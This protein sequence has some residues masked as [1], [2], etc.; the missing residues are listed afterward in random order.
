MNK[1][2]EHLLPVSLINIYLKHTNSKLIDVT[3]CKMGNIT[4]TPRNIYILLSYNFHNTSFRQ[5]FKKKLNSAI[6]IM[7]YR[8]RAPINAIDEDDGRI[9]S[10]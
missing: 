2:D 3:Y 1:A 8:F 4:F 10:M 6:C 5:L 9:L 7:L